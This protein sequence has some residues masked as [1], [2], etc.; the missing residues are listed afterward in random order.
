VRIQTL[1]DKP[2]SYW[3]AGYAGRSRS[4]WRGR[5]AQAGG[6]VVLMNASHLLDAV[7]HLTRL[8]V[9]RVAG[10]AGTLLAPADVEVEDIAVATMR[11]ENGALGSLI[12]GAHLAG[13]REGDEYF[14]LYG[15]GGQ[16]R[17]PDPY[18]DGPLRV[19]LR[20][21]WRDLPAGEWV[22]VRGAPAPVHQRAVEDFARAVQAGQPAPI[23]GHDARRVLATVL[24]LYASAAEGRA[25]SLEEPAYAGH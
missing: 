25:I 22:E 13:A 9:T 17:L 5:R 16:M 14:D 4:P 2:L 15:S 1:I 7:W 3:Q 21:A 23:S 20:E 10:E 6:G 11:F 19:F 12:A 8:A 24:A 18:T